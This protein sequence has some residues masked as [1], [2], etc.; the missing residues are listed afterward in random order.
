MAYETNRFCWHGAI[1]SDLDRA[2]GFYAETLGWQVQIAEMGDGEV[3]MFAAAG[4]PLAHLARPSAEGIGSHWES[5]LRV[6]DV[7]ASTAAAVQHGGQVLVAPTDIAP[8]RL[9]VVTSPGG[10]PLSLFHEADPT[11]EHHP[12]GDGSVRWVELHSKQIE[13]DL[14]WLSATFGFGAN[15]V[16]VPR[17]AYFVLEHGGVPRGGALAS[18]SE[19]DPPM[20]LPWIQVSSADEA[21]ER[22]Q[23]HGGRGVT[24][25][26]DVPGVGRVAIMADPTGGVLGVIAPT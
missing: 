13:A 2:E 7:D 11:A 14:A 1:T 8:G 6:D 9:S 17:G 20:W 22:A 10:A 24:P 25:P 23:Q 3:R 21:L 19:E 18:R 4:V 26:M 5:Y 16:D 12:G 15:K